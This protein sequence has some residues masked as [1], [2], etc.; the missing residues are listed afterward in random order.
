MKRL[1][2]MR[3]AKS[4]WSDPAKDDFER[5]LN[6]RGIKAARFMAKYISSSEYKPDAVLCSTARRARET[7]EPLHALLPADVPV[8][9]RDELYHAMPDVMLDEIHQAPA[10]AKTLLVV[11]HNPGLVLLAMGLAE[12]PDE[13]VAL[14]VANGV[15][16]GGF[17][18]FEFDIDDWKGVKEGK[19]RTVFFGR[20]RDLMASSEK[21]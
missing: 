8:V 21:P 19:G 7:F 1:C 17:I 18:V 4:D 9:F 10:D 15:P 6:P 11:A 3:H 12:D 13:E 2:L 14:R 5:A 20:P 16:T